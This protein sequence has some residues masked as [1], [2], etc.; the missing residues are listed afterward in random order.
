MVK[1]SVTIPTKSKCATHQTTRVY[2]HQDTFSNGQ[3]PA[4]LWRNSQTTVTTF[5]TAVNLLTL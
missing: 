2:A 1:I 5:W 4:Q 3:R